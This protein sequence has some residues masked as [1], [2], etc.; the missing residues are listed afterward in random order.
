MCMVYTILCSEFQ[1]TFY[2]YSGIYEMLAHTWTDVA[3]R[4][5]KSYILYNDSVVKE[6]STHQ[7]VKILHPKQLGRIKKPPI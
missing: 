3:N 2:T 4:L 6:K 5:H 1:Q 7:L